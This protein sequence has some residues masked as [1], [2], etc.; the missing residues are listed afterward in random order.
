MKGMSKGTNRGLSARLRAIEGVLLLTGALCLGWFIGAHAASA[1][2]Q[3]QLSRELEQPRPAAVKADPASAEPPVAAAPPRGGVIGRI[4][5]PRLRL[6]AVA[7]EGADVRTLRRAVGHVPSTALPGRPGN[8][9]FA[10]HRD[11]FFRPLKDVRIGDE[12]LVTTPERRYRYI[13]RETQV[14]KPSDVWVLDPTPDPSLTLVTCYPFN[15]FGAA[16]RRFIVR[17]TLA[18]EQPAPESAASSAASQ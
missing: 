2:E 8:A 4:E 16:P 9:A 3:A 13:V 15:Y 6:S 11:T 7:R 12:V 17:A 18:Q 14:V 5:V 1:R 10:G